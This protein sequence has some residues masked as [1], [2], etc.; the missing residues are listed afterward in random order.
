MK[1]LVVLFY[2]IGLLKLNAQN[3]IDFT[4]IFEKSDGLESATYAET[5]DFYQ[6][7]ADFYPEIEIKEMGKTDSGFPLHIVIFNTDKEFDFKKIKE[8]GKSTL[9]IN[10]GIHPG[11]PDGIDA[12]MMFLRDL[13]QN[14]KLLKQYQNT[15]IFIIPVYNIGGA[16]NRNS[17][18]RANQNG[19]KE[20]GFRGNARNFDLNRDF[21]KSDTKNTLAFTEIFHQ[22]NPDIF[23]DTHVSNGAD[24]QYSLTHLFTQH[25]KLG[26]QLGSYLHEK[27]MP[28][29]IDDL[30]KKNIPVTP[31]VNVFNAPPDGGFSQYFD[32][33]RY[34]TGYTTLFNTLGVM[35]ETHMLKPY[36]K[37]VQVT[38]EFLWSSL[39]FLNNNGKEIKL[40]RA[41]ANQ[42]FQNENTY[43]IQWKIDSTKTSKLQFKGYEAVYKKSEVTGLDRL[44]YDQTKPFEK[45]ITYYNYF[46]PSKEIEIPMAYIIPQ[47]WWNVIEL[48]KINK[49]E[50][51]QFEKD[52]TL[53]V[54][55]YQIVDYKSRTKPYEGHFPHYQIK[56]NIIKKEVKFFKGDYY[57]S[58][59][60]N[61][62][63]YLL[64][65]LEPE[66]SDSFLSW[67]FFDSILQ[68]KEGFSPYV[69]EET[70]KEILRANNQLN[71]DFEH[72][73]NTDESFR[74]NAFAQL[75]FIYKNSEFAENSFL[76]YPIYRIP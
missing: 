60:Q 41:L 74:K 20:Y 26:K 47:G 71:I 24:Y 34:S 75:Y 61:G 12:S 11:E 56:T 14:K 54:E 16:L 22:T 63:R 66:A 23:I 3:S 10:N 43:P 35:I 58:T 67:N 18:T 45:E 29:I 44:F 5:I 51:K 69:F 59:K 25:N 50:M 36:P 17:T 64:E 6:K 7:L 52:T 13:V 4:T 73:K 72:K 27:M 9:L 70:A 48:L 62:I 15:V 19:P 49:I 30:N 1:K 38:Y 28:D 65:T 8:S 46:K 33:P 37:R 68:E 42:E 55:S 32:S 57:I 2:C 39:Q 21:I 31:Y 53:I 40:K 76:I